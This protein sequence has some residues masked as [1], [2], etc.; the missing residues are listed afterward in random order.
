MP[1]QTI[2]VKKGKWLWWGK[3]EE[4]EYKLDVDVSRKRAASGGVV[5][6]RRGEFVCGFSAPYAFEDIVEAEL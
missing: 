5:H 3:P 2:P 1:V 6:N 4:Q